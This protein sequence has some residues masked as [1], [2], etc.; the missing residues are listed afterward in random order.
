MINAGTQ[1]RSQ[2][3]GSMGKK[4]WHTNIPHSQATVREREKKKENSLIQM[5]FEA[6]EF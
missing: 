1:G 3:V 2:E 5:Q 4:I 6:Q